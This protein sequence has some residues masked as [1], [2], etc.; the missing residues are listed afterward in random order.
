MGI[1]RAETLT[2]LRLPGT[3]AEIVSMVWCQSRVQ[4]KFGLIFYVLKF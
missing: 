2:D 1:I 4:T 3:V